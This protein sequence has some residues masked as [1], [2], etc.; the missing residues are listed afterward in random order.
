[1]N[2]YYYSN[3]SATREAIKKLCGELGYG[4]Y[5]TGVSYLDMKLAQI[6]NGE[7]PSSGRSVLTSVPDH[8]IFSG[9]I[10]KELDPFLNAYRNK[11]IKR[12]G[13]KAVV[14]VH[15]LSWTLRDLLSELR[16]EE[17]AFAKQK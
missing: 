2:I 16:E 14:T 1:M 13:L 17:K 9:D 10:Q 6:V 11:G 4:C 7:A 3:D 8:I 5:L 15:N 12:I